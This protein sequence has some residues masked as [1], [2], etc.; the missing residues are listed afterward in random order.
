[1]SG[2]CLFLGTPE[3]K[4]Y[5]PYLKSLF[6]GKTTYVVCGGEIK[7]LTMLEL[8]CSK[9]EITGVVCTDREI[10]S[11]LL[12]EVGNIRSNPSLDDYQGSV[13]TYKSV[14]I[15]F[16]SPL[17]QLFTVP[18]GKFIAQ[19]FISKVTQPTT[20]AEPTAFSWTLLKPENIDHVYE[21]FSHAYAIA[22]D[23]ETFRDPLSIR[24]IGFTAVF[25]DPNGT[26]TSSS[27]VLPLDSVW[28]L[29]WMR[30]FCTLPV[31]KIF[32]NGKYDISYLLRYNSVPTE[33]YWD[34]ANLFHSYYSELPKDLAYL[35]AFFLRKVV[36]WKDLAESNDLFEY[37][38]YNA[39]DTWATAN[40]W[41]RQLIELPEWARRNYTLEFP[42]NYPCLLSEMTGLRRDPERL[43]ES[44]H[45]VDE[46]IK[47]QEGTLRR[48][49]DLPGFNTNSPT[50]V[51]DLLKLLGCGDITSTQEKDLQKASYRHPLNGWIIGK[52]IKNREAR[53][54][55]S[56]YL[57][58]P[59]D[60]KGAAEFYGRILYSLNPNGTDSGRLASRKHHFWCGLQ[61][62]NIPTG[63]E[64]KRTLRCE[65][66]FYLGECD[67]EQAESRDTGYLSG[68]VSLIAALTSGKDFHSTN[69]SAFFGLTYEQIY[70]DETGKT[71]NKPLRDLSK[72]TNHGATYNMGE[73]VMLDTMGLE[74]VWE[75]KRLLKLSFTEPLKITG[76]LLDRFHATYPGIRG[77]NKPFSEGTFYAHIVREI[78]ETKKLVS[79]AY[80]HTR[81]N[82]SKFPDSTAYIENG[83]WTRYCF[84]NPEKSKPAL[85]SYVSH[86]SQSL[87]AR[88]LNEAYMEVFYEIALPNPTDFRLHAQIHDS[89]LFSYRA[90]FQHLASQ[91][92]NLMEI[93]VTVQNIRGEYVTFT[94]PAA[95]KLG[96]AD[97]PAVYWNETE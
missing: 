94:V 65:D 76:Y 51:K 27:A 81:Y 28:A 16:I 14:E 84:G 35:N 47:E 82:L 7:Y 13:F 49:L 83:D 59:S 89:I 39:L 80:H 21:N 55:K 34:T 12:A 19:R 75:A 45:A 48:V 36:Y 87:N 43:L 66:G 95:L 42:L 5:V 29:A 64:V 40:V 52:I 71:K 4:E 38:K 77:P 74:K 31:Q 58:L 17:K 15:V 93:P 24:C 11:K 23:I 46:T 33:W 9:R 78:S 22:A 2:N 96:K 56:T 62:Q 10:L 53:K 20:W 69:A 6:S 50:Q 73:G 67:L 70:D 60:E 91:V 90:G 1:M 41:I 88:T 63:P 30:K 92:K 85:N 44:R 68:D 18:Y 32:Q 25:V 79:R 54:L 26:L 61:I 57:S 8:Y 37:Y 72:R 86:P 97:K 3:D